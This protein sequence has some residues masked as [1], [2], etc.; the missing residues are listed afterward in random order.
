MSLF[1]LPKST[2][3]NIDSI[4][5]HFW[6]GTSKKEGNYY[7]PKSWDF[8]CQLK[9]ISGLGFRRAEDSNKA[10]LSKT[11]WAL[12]KTNISLAG[13]AIK[14]KYGN[15]LKSSNRS[16]PSPIWRG[17]Q[18]CKDT[19]KNNTCFSVGNGTSILVWHDPWIPSINDHKPSPRSDTFQDPNLKVSDLMLN[20]PKR[21]N[22]PL[23]TSLFEQ[24]I[25]QNII[26]IHLTQ[27]NL[28]DSAQW[29]PNT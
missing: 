21:W 25:V 1:R 20:H 10:M 14:A 8:I 12:T 23:L 9:A 24:A 17:L 16:S 4:T 11:S 13:R 29:T 2:L 26:K 22:I 15:F 6:W 5:K 7:A 3:S 18:W 19:I 28:E 27:G